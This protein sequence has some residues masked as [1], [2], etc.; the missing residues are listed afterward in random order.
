[1]YGFCLG[2]R[3]AFMCAVM[4]LYLYVPS[5]TPKSINQIFWMLCRVIRIYFALENFFCHINTAYIQRISNVRARATFAIEFPVFDA[6][7]FL[8]SIFLILFFCSSLFSF[9]LDVF[10]PPSMAY[11]N[12]QCYSIVSGA[13]QYDG[14]LERL[15][16]ESDMLKQ[17]YGHFFDLTIA[18]NNITETILALET[19]IEK[20]HSSPQW[21]PVPWLYWQDSE[22]DDSTEPCAECING[23]CD[24]EYCDINDANG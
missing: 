7:S 15:S 22:L 18:N 9:N 4:C 2:W 10:P 6:T 8:L 19:A 20:L 14:S 23:E 11:H 21:V 1:M 13:M 5:R 12:L 16:K 24:C 17:A 3:F